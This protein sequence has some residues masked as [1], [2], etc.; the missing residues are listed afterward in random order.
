M[1]ESIE[2]ITAVSA[3]SSVPAIPYPANT[4]LPKDTVV[5]S[6]TAQATLMA[7]NGDSVAEI[8]SSLGIPSAEVSSDLGL[9]V[10]APQPATPTQTPA[11]VAHG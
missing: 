4:A 7:Q 6:Y 1:A 3:T 10:T 8:A 2:A 11:V 5:L 9:T